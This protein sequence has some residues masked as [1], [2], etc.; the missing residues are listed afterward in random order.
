MKI[1]ISR[2]VRLGWIFS[3]FAA[4][5]VVLLFIFSPLVHAQGA[6][7]FEE[8]EEQLETIRQVFTFIKDNYVDEV[9]PQVLIEGA[10]KGMFESLEDPYS[11]Y[12]DVTDMRSLTDTTSGKFGGVGLYINKIAPTDAQPELQEWVEIVSPIEGTPAFR[13]GLR[14]RDYIVEIE[15]ETT[16]DLSIEEVVNKLRGDVGTS[17]EVTILR[18]LK[19]RF[20]VNLRRAIIQIPT[21]RYG[22]IQDKTGYVRIIQFTPLTAEKV[23]DALQDLKSQGYQD[24]IIDLRTN[25]GG[26]LTS[27]IETADLFLDD[28]L[29]VGTAGRSKGE[30]QTYYAKR[31]M[32]L[33]KDAQIVVMINEGTASAAE[34]LA[35]AL[36]DSDRAALVGET[37]FG[38]GSVQQVRGLGEG[39]FRLTMAKYYTPSRV[40]IDKIGVVPDI[41]VEEAELSEEENQTLILVQEEQRIEAFLDRVDNTP[42]E[43]QLR[44]FI[45]GLRSEGLVANE[46]VLRRLITVEL[47]TRLNSISAFDLEY[48]LVLQEAVRIIRGNRT[49][50]IIENREAISPDIDNLNAF[51]LR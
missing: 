48:D 44:S 35:G 49:Q 10:L 15:G 32:S 6:S 1:R 31:G 41:V 23:A 38:K 5:T 17:V 11:A 37:S 2:N 46:R 14:P 9:D 40:F 36:K 27:A 45:T 33:S 47:E 12:L 3:I 22:G 18:N 25:P 34:I 28:G 29:I 21:V 4:L 20:Q 51:Q 42:T 26:L 19:S 39:G 13:A 7:A 30:N 24:M 50:S 8:E 16:I 43:A